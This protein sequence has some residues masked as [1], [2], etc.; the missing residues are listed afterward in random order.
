M[1]Y[2]KD[3]MILDIHSF[4][5]FLLTKCGFDKMDVAFIRQMYDEYLEATEMREMA[6]EAIH[7]T[8]LIEECCRKLA[9]DLLDELDEL[10]VYTYEKTLTVK[11]KE[12]M[13]NII[14]SM[15][16]NIDNTF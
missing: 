6:D 16:R 1:I 12:E 4:E 10:K 15:M 13:R 2:G 14:N 7:N 3:F 9:S 11:K 8:Y 5:D